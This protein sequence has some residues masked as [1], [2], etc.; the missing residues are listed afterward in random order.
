MALAAR[1]VLRLVTPPNQA[2]FFFFSVLDFQ[3]KISE[4]VRGLLAFR[5]VL[6]IVLALT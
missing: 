1:V 5:L 3:K 2:L 6:V 4:K